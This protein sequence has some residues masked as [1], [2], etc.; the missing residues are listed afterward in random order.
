M[1]EPPAFSGFVWLLS[2]Q[3]GALH[4]AQTE[5]IGWSFQLNLLLCK[6]HLCEI[7][8][9]NCLYTFLR[10]SVT[11]KCLGECLCCGIRVL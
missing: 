3:G 8:K 5:S 11:I 7:L 2:L 10:V 1:W 6:H 4:F 9:L